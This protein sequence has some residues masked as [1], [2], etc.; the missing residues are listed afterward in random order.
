MAGSASLHSRRDHSGTGRVRRSRRVRWGSRSASVPPCR[1]L[2]REGPE[3]PRCRGADMPRCRHAGKPACCCAACCPAGV[4]GA[5][6][7]YPIRPDKQTRTP[8]GGED[9]LARGTLTNSIRPASRQGRWRVRNSV[10]PRGLVGFPWGSSATSLR[11]LGTRPASGPHRYPYRAHIV[12][13]SPTTTPT[14][15]GQ[16]RRPRHR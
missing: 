15:I 10:M 12:A 1:V 9:E 3:E 4:P 2:P 6:E 16:S 14:T 13:H 8:T 5:A 11:G 7:I